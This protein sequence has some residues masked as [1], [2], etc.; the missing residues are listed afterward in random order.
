MDEINRVLLSL[1]AQGVTPRQIA[2]WCL[3]DAAKRGRPYWYAGE[4]VI[5]S[6]QVIRLPI[7]SV[8]GSVGSSREVGGTDVRP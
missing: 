8:R 6:G 4:T 7:Y 5:L 1:L 3:T 2:L